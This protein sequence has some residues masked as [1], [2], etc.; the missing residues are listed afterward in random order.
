M[1]AGNHLLSG[2][3]AAAE[4]A[5]DAVFVRGTDGMSYRTFFE[6]AER[7]AA[8]LVAEGVAPGD[9]VAA[10]VQKSVTALQLYVG[11]VM[12]GGIYLPLNTAYKGAEIAYFLKDAEP[13]IFVGDPS[14]E[15]DLAGEVAALRCQVAHARRGRRQGT[16]AALQ[17]E[18]CAGVR[19]GRAGSR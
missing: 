3:S 10:Q 11:T 15:A 14:V 16:L 2:L 1:Y 13:V 6:G 5:P 8:A 12:A 9:R 19:A 18:A 7:M 4:T 17:A